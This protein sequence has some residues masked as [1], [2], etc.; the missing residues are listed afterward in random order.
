MLT[1]AEA[2]VREGHALEIL[3]VDRGLGWR[4]SGRLARLAASPRVGV[5][6]CSR[7]ARDERVDP[8]ALPAWIRWS[9]L[10]SWFREHA[11]MGPLWGV[12]P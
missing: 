4:D 5:A 9:S 3:L 8:E 6:L 10:V 1:K 7:S 2:A 12:L 11:A